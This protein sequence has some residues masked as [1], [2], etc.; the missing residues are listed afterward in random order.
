MKNSRNT[1]RTAKP[2]KKSKIINKIDEGNGAAA[3]KGK[4][5][6]EHD[7]QKDMERVPGQPPNF[8]RSPQDDEHMDLHDWPDVVKFAR[9]YRFVSDDLGEILRNVAIEEKV[10]AITSQRENINSHEIAE[11]K[12][13]LKQLT[14]LAREYADAVNLS[15]AISLGI[16]TKYRIR[17]GHL[18]NMQKKL[19][20]QKEWEDFYYQN[21]DPDQYQA[22]QNW[23]KMAAVPN[24][25][26]YAAL[27]EARLLEI[28]R[29]IKNHPSETDD[30][31]GDFM[32]KNQLYIN[33]NNAGSFKDVEIDID[34][35]IA[36]QKIDEAAALN[37][38]NIHIDTK[39]LRKLIR[40]RKKIDAGLIK[41]LLV[42]QKSA[43]D[44]NQLLRDFYETGQLSPITLPSGKTVPGVS[45]LISHIQTIN[46][47]VKKNQDQIDKISSKDIEVMETQ[48]AKLKAMK[49]K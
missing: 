48:I 15:E 10:K 23:I 1:S 43:G 25:I 40:K 4:E 26:R 35:I 11:K 46:D 16:I 41:T 13:F 38:V 24:S 17:L 22:M 44:P 5:V 47:Y 31:I 6:T 3:I 18:F 37:Q 9:V 28:I 2:V 39:L 21:F 7:D 29:A 8:T 42:I 20:P 45:K 33:L 30:P 34:V 49:G 19:M 27:G 32:K 12:P 36:K 14:L